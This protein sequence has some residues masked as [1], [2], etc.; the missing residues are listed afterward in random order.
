M[1]DFSVRRDR[2]WHFVNA[3]VIVARPSLPLLLDDLL[4]LDRLIERGE[5]LCD[6]LQCE[7]QLVHALGNAP[8][9]LLQVRHVG[10]SLAGQRRVSE[11][12][13]GQSHVVRS[14]EH[15]LGHI[16]A[17]PESSKQSSR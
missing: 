11:H 7:Q 8:K 3:V 1:T 17:A 14:R 12:P 9:H 4:D 16:S 6:A 2:L 13:G 10:A 5:L 15:D